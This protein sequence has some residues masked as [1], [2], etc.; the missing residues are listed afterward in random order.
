[1]SKVPPLRDG[2][3]ARHFNRWGYRGIEEVRPGRFRA[4]L[5]GGDHIL[6]SKYFDTP[7][8]AAKAYDRMARKIYGARGFYNF[9]KQPGERK[10]KPI[11]EDF[12]RLGHARKSN[13]YYR[14]DNGCAAYCRLCNRLAQIRSAAR[15]KART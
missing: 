10:V 11:D 8:E 13:T 7:R 9:P 3:M 2:A 14:P 4:K 6:R 5:G 12:C 1:M 15:R